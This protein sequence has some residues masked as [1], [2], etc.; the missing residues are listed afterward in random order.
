MHSKIFTRRDVT[1]PPYEMLPMPATPPCDHPWPLVPLLVFSPSCPNHLSSPFD[2]YPRSLKIGC[3]NNQY[4]GIAPLL[5][6]IL[7]SFLSFHFRCSL[8]IIILNLRCLPVWV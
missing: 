7:I 8:G 5:P 4:K 6:L 1:S 3:T 2:S